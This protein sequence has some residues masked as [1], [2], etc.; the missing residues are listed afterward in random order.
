MLEASAMGLQL[1]PVLKALPPLA[2]DYQLST[3]ELTQLIALIL[4]HANNDIDSAL[5]CK[6]IDKVKAP[7]KLA[8]THHHDKED[9]LLALCQCFE[10]INH[11]E[12]MRACVKSAPKR[13]TPLW[14]YYRVYSETNGNAEKC[15][16]LNISRLIYHRDLAI[17]AKDDRTVI[18]IEKFVDKYF[19]S[20][21]TK[22][23]NAFSHLPDGN[24][25]DDA[26]SLFN[27]LPNALFNKLDKKSEEIIK[28]TSIDSFLMGIIKRHFLNNSQALILISQDYSIL[29]AF[30]FLKAADEL[31]IDTQVTAA[32]IVNYVKAKTK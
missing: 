17:E 20:K 25:E 10:R 26:I 5:L 24:D 3:S 16:K 18:L 6:I 2:K 4:Q 23:G 19:A 31:N 22:L 7:I 12:L 9:E 13:Y 21:N 28:K 29:Q 15:S 30:L 14:M 8:I 27:H 32:D 11:F 1:T